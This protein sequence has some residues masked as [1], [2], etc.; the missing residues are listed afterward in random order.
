MALEKAI[1][2]YESAVTAHLVNVTNEAS[3]LR[4]FYGSVRFKQDKYDYKEAMRHDLDKATTAILQLRKHVP[5]Q[6]PSDEDLAKVLF[7]I[8]EDLKSSM[9]V[10]SGLPNG[11]K[12]DWA[13]YL[14]LMDKLNKL[15]GIERETF[16]KSKLFIR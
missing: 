12:Y 15:Q 13:S 16:L 8:D 7:Q 5:D 1:Q 3:T 9:E 10:V 14:Q 4:S 6:Q 2:D 11:K